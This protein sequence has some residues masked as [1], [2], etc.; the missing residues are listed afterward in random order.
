M[1]LVEVKAFLNGAPWFD[2]HEPRLDP[3]LGYDT[4]WSRLLD[5]GIAAMI[6]VFRQFANADLAERLT[7]CCWP[8]LM[9]A[10]AVAASVASAVRLGGPAAGRATLVGS[11]VALLAIPG[12][13]RPGEIDHH[14]AQV[15][16][17]LVMIALIL[18]CEDSLLLAAA[19]GV[20]G[21]VLL[22]VGLEAATVVVAAAATFALLV[23]WDARWNAPA[24]AFALALGGATLLAW[25]G[26]T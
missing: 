3:P 8:L 20:T 26:L 12:I 13:F 22:G 16:L 7:R 18:W 21:G 14:N 23:V 11:L 6:I 25:A 4:H 15:M 2:P 17:A 1:R 24:R 19:A 9:S 5:A 10:P